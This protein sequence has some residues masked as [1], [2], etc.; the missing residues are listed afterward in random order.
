MKIKSKKFKREID[1]L[2][3][4]KSSLER[5]CKS[6][7]DEL[8]SK[9]E[10]I[11]GLKTSVSQ[12]TSSS[13]GMEAEL[14]QT[15][16]MLSNSQEHVKDLTKLSDEQTAKIE[17]YEENARAFET[18]RRK[19]HN[20]IQELKGNIRVFCRIRPLLKD[21][22]G[23]LKHIELVDDKSLALVKSA[24]SPNE[25]VAT[26]LKGK[27]SRYDFQFDKVFKPNSGQSEVF[28]EISQ[29]V[30]SA[31]DGYHVCVFAYGQTGSGKTFTMEGGENEGQEGMIPKTIEKIFEETSR[32]MEK[33][34]EYKL[35]ANFLEIYNEDIRD[36]LATEKI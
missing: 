36:L 22:T 4:S 8:N 10:E 6:L 18:E 2:E 32:L 5:K 34:W 31:I 3:F 11:A 1:D 17:I 30:Q 28:E 27:A 13:A 14:K 21:E 35:E 15:K 25:S 33:G 19:L 7:E 20:T 12:L 29:L 23:D 9:M 26:G 16:T 24:D